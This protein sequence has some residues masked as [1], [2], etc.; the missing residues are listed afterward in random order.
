MCTVKNYS[1]SSALK[2]PLTLLD[3]T[4]RAKFTAKLCDCSGTTAEAAGCIVPS[5]GTPTLA[6]LQGTIDYAATKQ[7]QYPDSKTVIVFLTDGEPGF[8]FTPPGGTV[9]QHLYSCDDLPTKGSSWP[10]GSNC[11]NDSTVCTTPD[12]E[13]QKVSLVIQKAPA[14]SIYVAGVGTDLSAQTLDTWATASGNDA[15]NLL[16]MTGAEAGAALMARLESIRKSSIKCVFPM[17]TST[18]G[19]SIAPDKTNVSYQPGTG[20]ASFLFR[21]ADGT[22]SSCGSAT[23]SWYFDDP[24]VPTTITLCPSTCDSLQS[25]PNGK[26]QLVFG[27]DVVVNIL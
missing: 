3:D 22:I 9:Q 18:T 17:P 24:K 14:G 5:G 27:C 20:K 25:D 23:N 10:N 11:V 13:V 26:I 6:A 21:T 16:N 19:N 15:I 1:S 2:V 7:A 4:G 8:G 12:D